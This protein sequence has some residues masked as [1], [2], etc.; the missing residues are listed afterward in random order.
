[1]E[2]PNLVCGPVQVCWEKFARYFDVEIRE[3]PMDAGRYLMEAEQCLERCD[4]NTIMV[5]ATLGQTFTGLFE[6]VRG[7][8]AALDGL[9]AEGGPDIP[10][11]VDGASGG[12]LAPFTAPELNGTSAW[13]A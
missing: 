3:V 10:L 2:R 6:D 8:A 12:F 9:Q 13:S 1:M 7:I 11:H 5:V 4:E